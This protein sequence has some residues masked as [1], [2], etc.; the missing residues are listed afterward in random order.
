MEAVPPAVTKVAASGLDTGIA[1]FLAP[2]AP[3]LVERVGAR[4]GDLLAF[5]AD[6]PKVVA[7]VLG[8]LRLKMV[9]DLG[10]KLAG[11]ARGQSGTEAPPKK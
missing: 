11:D 7:K 4:E 5:A 6:T 8:E 3:K 9:R 1:K 10:I 2:I